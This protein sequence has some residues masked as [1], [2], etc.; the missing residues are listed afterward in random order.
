M[1]DGN[2]DEMNCEWVRDMYPDVLHGKVEAAVAE[3]V[4]THVGS[5]DECRGEIAL[6]EAIHAQNAP[7]P[8]GLHERILDAV[9]RP[10]PRFRIQ[11]G[12]IA[13]AATVAAAL[14][15]GSLILH[16]QVPAPAHMEAGPAAAAATAHHGI[17]AV[18]VED[19]MLSGKTSLDDLTVEQLEKLLGETIS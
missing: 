18:G 19:A 10:A 6:L 12:R 1:T 2:R 15:G 9:G 3:R 8:A 4:R 17:G 16:Q 13:M 7:V 5:C 11:A 14:I